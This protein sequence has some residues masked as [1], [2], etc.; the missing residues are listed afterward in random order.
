MPANASPHYQQDSTAHGSSDYRLASDENFTCFDSQ[1]SHMLRFASQPILPSMAL[2]TSVR[3][4]PQMPS[5][6]TCLLAVTLL[7]AS[8]GWAHACECRNYVVVTTFK[9][10][11][12][13]MQ[14][15]KVGREDRRLE[16][17]QSS[18][19]AF[20]PCHAIGIT[21]LATVYLHIQLVP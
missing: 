7:A 1:S 17:S 10:C 15:C 2:T 11:D 4:A 14:Y 13:R 5:I 12:T 21:L 20:E 18:P 8:V 19:A 9:L 16:R 3:V 6:H